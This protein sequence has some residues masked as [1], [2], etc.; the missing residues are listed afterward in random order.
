MPECESAED[1]DD[2][3]ECTRDACN[4]QYAS[5][6]N[7]PVPDGRRCGGQTYWGDPRG[8]C[9]AGS[10]NFRPVSVAVGEK[11]VVFD[12]SAERCEDFDVPDGP[13]RVVRA[14]DGELVLFATLDVG[15]YLSR[16]S[17]FDS[18]ERDCQRSPLES[19][20]LPTPESYENDEWLWSPYR[21][22]A[23]WHVLIH[24]E[25]H[26][27][28]PPPCVGPWSPCWY[29]SIT[30]AVSTDGARSFVKPSPPK[31]VVAPA[32]GVWTP[33]G[34][35]TPVQDWYAEG[36]FAP[37]NIVRG[38]EDYYYTLFGHLDWAATELNGPCL[39]RTKTLH[40]PTS[41]QAWD[42]TAFN[43]ALESP[44]DVGSEVPV[45]K[46]LTPEGAMHDTASLTYNN[47]LD[48]YMWVGM[49]LSWETGESV[50][51]VYFTTSFD[52]IHWSDIQLIAK[53]LSWCE[54]DPSTPGLLEPVR[55][56]Y[57][58]IID[59]A[60]STINFERPGQT[61][62]LYYTRHNEGHWLDRDLVR[63]PLTF[64]LEE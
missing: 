24:N 6:E 13:T 55:I 15:N 20:N 28:E 33:P 38:P 44:Y 17:D 49:H 4:P 5:C 60:D 56:Q 7:T 18:F 3:N 57:P 52:L 37:S 47:Y 40:D 16:G 26:P 29:N 22:G 25:F 43:L 31:H 59:H 61:P 41:W 32:P 9:Y 58:S 30:Y 42:G 8:G 46:I 14:E 63:V 27:L 19:A 62:Y 21:E 2:E 50:C 1:C 36:Y 10:C 11:E 35:E 12:W 48:R 64:T 45:C 39:M 23:S 34:P 51:G 53:G 54:T